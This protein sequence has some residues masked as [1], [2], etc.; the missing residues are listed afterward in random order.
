[1]L[2]LG[3]FVLL[4]WRSPAGHPWLDAGILAMIGFAVYGPQFLVGVMVADVAT[5]HAASTAIGLTGLFGYASG[6]VSGWGLGL[7]LDR[8]GWTGGFVVLLVCALASALPFA[9]TWNVRP[10]HLSAVPSR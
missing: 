2:S 6:L 7:V 3:A 4:F 8:Y 1:M 10:A 9:V 5:K